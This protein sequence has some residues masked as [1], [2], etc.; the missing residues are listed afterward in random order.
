MVGQYRAK[1]AMDNADI[2][3]R[4]RLTE[5]VW[6]PIKAEIDNAENKDMGTVL[7]DAMQR[8]SHTEERKAI[9]NYA[10][11]LLKY[12]GYNIA[13][14]VESA[15]NGEGADEG[16]ASYS[17]GYEAT[18]P[19]QMQEAKAK[20]ETARKALEDAGFDIDNDNVEDHVEMMR[21]AVDEE[22]NAV[23]TSEE[24]QPYVDYMNA[25]ARYDGMM[26]RVEDDIDS[27]IAASDAIVDG[28]THKTDGMV[29]SATLSENGNKRQVYIVFV[30]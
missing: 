24:I 15:E 10:E 7:S 14:T 28:R 29:H 9:L 1:H 3:A 11:K 21:G 17:A 20:Y 25:K 23:F 4:Y 12:R 6:N 18:D 8:V 13:T 16:D 2:L 30:E 27:R 19:K 26:Q 22:G 5:D